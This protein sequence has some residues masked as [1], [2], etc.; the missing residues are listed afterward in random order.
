MKQDVI[1]KLFATYGLAVAVGFLLVSGGEF[2]QTNS[3]V[4]DGSAKS[5]PVELR[6]QEAIDRLAGT[7]SAT[8]RLA[9]EPTSENNGK[10][11]RHGYLW[12][13]PLTEAAGV[14]A[15]ADQE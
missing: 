6:R 11:S 8:L 5:A 4:N 14:N 7:M 15:R 12:S 13:D 1:F 9:D 2:A 3:I 10:P